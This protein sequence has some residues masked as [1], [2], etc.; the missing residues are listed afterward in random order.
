MALYRERLDFCRI[1]RDNKWSKCTHVP[2]QTIDDLIRD[3]RGNV[4]T[5]C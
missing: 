5:F 1:K 3:E 2:L 4:I